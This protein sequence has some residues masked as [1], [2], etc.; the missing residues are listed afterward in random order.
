MEREKKRARERECML[1]V[2]VQPARLP[3]TVDLVRGS[4]SAVPS[5]SWRG[6]ERV[7]MEGGG[8]GGGESEC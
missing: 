2:V 1:I 7:R 3:R 8:G 5:T 4:R 6:R